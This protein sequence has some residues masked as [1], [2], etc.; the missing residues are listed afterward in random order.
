[1][2]RRLQLDPARFFPADPTERA[3]AARLFAVVEG[4]PIVSP[5]GLVLR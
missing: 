5:H 2:S 3:I 1:M 4:L